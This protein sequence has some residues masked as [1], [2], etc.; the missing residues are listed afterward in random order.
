MMSSLSI[1]RWGLPAGLSNQFSGFLTPYDDSY[2]S[3]CLLLD[4]VIVLSEGEKYRI[5]GSPYQ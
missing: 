2:P 5:W 4:D 3:P 1:L